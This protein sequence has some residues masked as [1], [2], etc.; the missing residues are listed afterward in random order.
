MPELATTVVINASSC[1]RCSIDQRRCSFSVWNLYDDLC[2]HGHGAISEPRYGCSKSALQ[3]TRSEEDRCQ[4]GR[5]GKTGEKVVL[6]DGLWR[7]TLLFLHRPSVSCVID[8]LS[9][10]ASCLAICS[11]SH[12][13]LFLG[14]TRQKPFVSTGTTGAAFFCLGVFQ[15]IRVSL[16]DLPNYF[17][18]HNL[19]WEA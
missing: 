11:S 7:F 6:C 3:G 2:H 13:Q 14:P 12:E 16:C 17:Y 1:P 18:R 15:G 9:V 8:L 10:E 5:R 4:N 19:Q